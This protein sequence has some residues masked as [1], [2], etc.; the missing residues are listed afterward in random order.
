MLKSSL[1]CK[2]VVEPSSLLL[3]AVLVITNVHAISHPTSPIRFILRML[4]RVNQRFHSFIVRTIRLYQVYYIELVSYIF[5]SVAYFK[6]VPLSVIA[7]W[8]IVF[9]NEIILKLSHLHCSSQIATLKSAFKHQC[10]VFHSY[11][12]L[13]NVIRF[14]LSVV[15]I[16]STSS[17]IDVLLLTKSL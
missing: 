1:E 15:F 4:D 9:E 13:Q 3:H 16:N 7:C 8:I 12:A 5:P 10:C 11:P 14:Q 17:L 6:K 2:S